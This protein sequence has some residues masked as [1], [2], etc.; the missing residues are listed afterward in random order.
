MKISDVNNVYFLGVGGIGM[1]ALARYFLAQGCKVYGYD[2]TKTH[3]TEQLEKEGVAIHY[4]EDVELVA[5]LFPSLEGLGV[6]KLVI[7]TP[8]IPKDNKEFV[9]FQQNEIKLYK[10]SE[11]LGLITQS[12]FTIAVAG[13]HGKTT[14]SSMVAH[15]LTACG[16]DCI[17]FLGGISLN[18]NSNLVLSDN[19]KI[20]VVEA[21]EFNDIDEFDNDYDVDDLNDLDFEENWN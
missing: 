2:K 7:Y 5:K 21:D 12:Y 4:E 15:V 14:T 19:A 1:S 8:A 3:L 9:Y 13:T 17:A 20:V 16:V 6:G 11:V 18:F 10:R